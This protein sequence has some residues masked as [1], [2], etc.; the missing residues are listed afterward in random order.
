MFWSRTKK[1]LNSFP[2]TSTF[3]SIDTYFTE[4]LWEWSNIHMWE[5]PG[6]YK[7]LRQCESLL[8]ICLTQTQ[9]HNHCSTMIWQINVKATMQI[10]R[11]NI[12]KTSFKYLLIYILWFTSRNILIFSWHTKS[13]QGPS[14]GVCCGGAGLSWWP[15]ERQGTSRPTD[16][17]PSLSSLP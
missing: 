1:S 9:N 15:W 7:M 17:P 2:Y 16:L 12:F 4:L 6:D 11:A 10:Y 14:S 3:D 5:G 13:T 8:L